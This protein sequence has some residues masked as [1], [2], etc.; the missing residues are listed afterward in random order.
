MTPLVFKHMCAITP[1]TPQV[2]CHRVRAADLPTGFTK[3]ATFD[4]FETYRL[5]EGGVEY[6]A[7]VDIAKAR[8][9]L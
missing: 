9:A 5:T 4:T 7:F 8:K 1:G 2:S 6:I 3:S